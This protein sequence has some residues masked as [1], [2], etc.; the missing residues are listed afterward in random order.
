MCNKKE[1]CKEGL[2]CGKDNCL[3]SG[4][5]NG[6]RLVDC[7]YDPKKGGPKLGEKNYCTRKNKCGENEGK[8]SNSIMGIC[9]TQ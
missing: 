4:F 2:K 7:C 1:D 5:W 9:G 6:A 8:I 3:K